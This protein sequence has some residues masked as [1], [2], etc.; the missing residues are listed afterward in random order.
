M[1]FGAILYAQDTDKGDKKSSEILDKLTKVTEAYKTIY[2]EFSYKMFNAEA[3]IDETTDGIL[4]IMGNNYK[5]N[6]AGQ[7]V[8]CDGETVWTYIKDVEEVQVNSVEEDEGSITPNKLLTAYNDDYRSK[9]I[10]EDFQY[11]ADVNIIDLSPLEGKSYY[12]VR[13]IID[14]AKDQLLEITIFDKNGSTYSYII[15]K[16]TPNV[17]VDESAFTF[18]ESDYPGV[19]VVDMR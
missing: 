5:H 1:A 2:I 12:K 11:G 6:I 16:F 14:K 18:N 13:L 3:D 10:R 17:E 4:T 9:F 7:Q 15:K 19:D 8:I